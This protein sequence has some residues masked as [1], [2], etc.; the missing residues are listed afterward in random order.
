VWYHGHYDP[1]DF[2]EHDLAFCVEFFARVLL[3]FEVEV[4]ANVADLL[5]VPFLHAWDTSWG[6]RIF[7]FFRHGG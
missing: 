2:S 5:C 6:D 3:Y 7:F 4:G 1:V